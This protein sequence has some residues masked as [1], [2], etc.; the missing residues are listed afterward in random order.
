MRQGLAALSTGPLIN[1]VHR[2]SPHLSS[3]PDLHSIPTLI[4]RATGPILLRELGVT[5]WFLENSSEFLTFTLISQLLGQ[6]HFDLQVE[7]LAADSSTIPADESRPG[8]H[9]DLSK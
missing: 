6:N 3:H 5:S 8:V 1:R 7:Q 9:S 2:V 4:K